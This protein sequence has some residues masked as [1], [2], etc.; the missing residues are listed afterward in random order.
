MMITVRPLN[1]SIAGSKPGGCWKMR[2]RPSRRGIFAKLP[3]WWSAA[4]QQC[5]NR[6]PK[7]SLRSTRSG[8]QNSSNIGV[9]RQPASSSLSQTPNS[10][11]A[12]ARGQWHRFPFGNR[13]MNSVKKSLSSFWHF[14][15]S[16]CTLSGLS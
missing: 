8:R 16:R 1:V 9:D 2:F 14:A 5:T 15:T 10:W 4:A 3:Y 12:H 13:R 6:P 11:G 7:L